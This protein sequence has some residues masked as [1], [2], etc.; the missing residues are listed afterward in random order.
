MTGFNQDDPHYFEIKLKRGDYTSTKF[1]QQNPICQCINFIN[2]EF[3]ETEAKNIFSSIFILDI[4]SVIDTSN[5]NDVSRFMKLQ[6][7]TVSS[8]D[9]EYWNNTGKI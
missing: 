4:E 9:G 5:N 7:Q 6:L 8:A 2:E 3:K 1:L